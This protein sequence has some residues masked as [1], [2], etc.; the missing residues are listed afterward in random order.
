MYLD[1]SFNMTIDK[2]HPFENE[3]TKLINLCLSLQGSNVLC[4]S[5]CFFN[6]QGKYLKQW[7]LYKFA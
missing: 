4:S 6:V 5:K 3:I 1:K 2:L 7:M